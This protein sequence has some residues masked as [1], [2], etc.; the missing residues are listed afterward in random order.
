MNEDTRAASID[1]HLD[2]V[3]AVLAKSGMGRPERRRII[4][5]LEVQ[6]HEMLAV[7]GENPCAADIRAT[8]A[9]LDP[10]EAYAAAID[11]AGVP[12]REQTIDPQPK[13]SI[14]AIIGA[15]WIPLFIVIVLTM[16]GGPT[17]FKTTLIM[18]TALMAPF[19]ATTL[20]WVAVS[21]IRHSQGRLYGIG[22]ALFDGLFFPLLTLSALI[23][24]GWCIFVTYLI[25]WNVLKVQYGHTVTYGAS[26]Y[27]TIPLTVL[28]SYFLDRYIVRRCLTLIKK[29]L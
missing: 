8:L 12:V 15:L 28:I 18:I 13:H 9:A 2:S 16:A 23:F 5:E 1:E 21:Q 26:F 4:D 20:G 19:G 29:S 14:L 7:Y 22:L 3:E 24:I 11:D 10:P 17:N 27:I 6:I 25:H